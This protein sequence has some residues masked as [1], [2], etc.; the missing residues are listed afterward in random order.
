MIFDLYFW[1]IG[2]DHIRK[3]V[4][5]FFAT[6]SFES[7]ASLVKGINQGRISQGGTP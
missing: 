4:P 5:K 1:N 3:V 2:R 7:V 6:T